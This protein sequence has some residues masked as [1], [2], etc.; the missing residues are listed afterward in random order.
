MDVLEFTWQSFAFTVI[1]FLVLVAILYRLLHKPLLDVLE[2]RQAGIEKAHRD[3]EAEA[4]R[5]RRKQ[6]EYEHKLA[7]IEEERD[8]LLTEARERAEEVRRELTAKARAEAERE[9]KH[10]R[11]DWQ[12]QRHDAIQS[13]ERDIVE[14]ALS[15]AR[16]VL[17][18]LA[19]QDIESK[20]Q[21]RLLVELDDLA[22]AK[23][24][25]RRG[26]F[27]GHGPVRVLSASP[28]SDQQ[29]RSIE[30]RVRALS[31]D[32]VEVDF[33]VEPALVAGGRVEFS[34]QALDASLADVVDAAR[35]TFRKLAPEPE[36]GQ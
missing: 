20:L 6:E 26:L 21:A 18:E 32:A 15:L 7:G 30:E 28:L 8:R 11:R 22:A 23:E 24:Q 2:R 33:A 12:R 25:Q 19:D 3:A 27:A 4:D 10:L 5:A 9:V 34:S 16:R 14:A 35:E 13:L 31:S 36:E 17:A 1:N 29:R